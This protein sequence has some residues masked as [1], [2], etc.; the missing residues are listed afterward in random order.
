MSSWSELVDGLEEA[1]EKLMQKV[2]MAEELQLRH[3]QRVR[4]I[5]NDLL[6]WVREREE[7]L[8]EP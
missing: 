7:W 3:I 2:P 6:D 8:E 5:A 4:E 1:R